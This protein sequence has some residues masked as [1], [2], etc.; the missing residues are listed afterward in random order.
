MSADPDV[1]VLAAA[2]WLAHH[3]GA[4]YCIR[5]TEYAGEWNGYQLLASD[6]LRAVDQA[7]TTT[8]ATT[9]TD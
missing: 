5:S 2:A 9:W 7:H 6:L 1:L 3:E 4:D 8:S